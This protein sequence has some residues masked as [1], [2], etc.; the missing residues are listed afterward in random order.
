MY[1]KLTPNLLV[2][3]ATKLHSSGRYFASGIAATLGVV[4]LGASAP[5][6]AARIYNLLPVAIYVCP[7]RVASPLIEG[8]DTRDYK[9]KTKYP[10]SNPYARQRSGGFG[11]LTR[12]GDACIFLDAGSE[13]TPTRSP[14][15]SWTNAV[16]VGVRLAFSPSTTN[17][18]DDRCIFSINSKETFGHDFQGGNY[19]VLR[20]VG[21]VVDGKLYDSGN[22]VLRESSGDLAYGHSTCPDMLK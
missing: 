12:S 7:W 21:K 9:D 3:I 15:I 19:L 10:D 14:S 6:E 4:A 13:A 11:A 8:W 20:P 16:A 22:Q 18:V 1:F 2:S 17:R 5:A